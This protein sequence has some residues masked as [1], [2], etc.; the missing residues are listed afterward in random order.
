MLNDGKRS[1]IVIASKHSI[2]EA[3][4]RIA[5]A[6]AQQ[7]VGHGTIGV[8]NNR[9]GGRSRRG[10]DIQR[11]RD[12]AI[13]IYND[14]RSVYIFRKRASSSCRQRRGWNRGP[15]PERTRHEVIRRRVG[16]N[17]AQ[18]A[19]IGVI[20]NRASRPRNRRARC[21]C[22]KKL[23]PATYFGPP[24]RHTSAMPRTMPVTKAS[25]RR[26]N[27]AVNATRVFMVTSFSRSFLLIGVPY[28]QGE[29]AERYARLPTEDGICLKRGKLSRRKCDAGPCIDVETAQRAAHAAG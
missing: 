1:E 29:V 2:E 20:G 13:G 9:D 26:N 27:R 11:H 24:A 16:Q 6:S 4:P 7:S 25:L 18:I 22:I 23:L 17:G 5:R 10:L 8:I 14:I 12:R 21:R 15:H 3:L 28:R 19:L